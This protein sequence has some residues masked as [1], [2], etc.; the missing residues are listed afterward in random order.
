MARLNILLDDDLARRLRIKA[1][2]IYG[3]TKGGLSQAI[4]DAVR[5]WLEKQDHATRKR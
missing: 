5:F 1:V 3:G 2:E 4:G